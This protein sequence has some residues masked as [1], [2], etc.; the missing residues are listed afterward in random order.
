MERRRRRTQRPERRPT[1]AQVDGG[2][3]REMRSI[4]LSPWTA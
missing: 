4:G 1:M 3:T 2:G